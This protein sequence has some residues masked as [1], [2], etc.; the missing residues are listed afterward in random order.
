[1]VLPS[2]EHTKERRAVE[3]TLEESRSR[4]LSHRLWRRSKHRERQSWAGAK[5]RLTADL[6]RAEIY[7]SFILSS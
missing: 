2:K 4:R 6:P 3:N 5:R 1:M 7:D